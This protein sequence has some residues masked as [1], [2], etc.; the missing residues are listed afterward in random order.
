MF[1]SRRDNSTLILLD[2]LRKLLATKPPVR[3]MGDLFDY[4]FS[5][6]SKFQWIAPSTVDLTKNNSA[7]HS[8]HRGSGG[9]LTTRDSHPAT[10]LQSIHATLSSMTL[11]GSSSSLSSTSSMPLLDVIPK[12]EELKW[13]MPTQDEIC[14]FVFYELLEDATDG[15]RYHFKCFSIFSDNLCVGER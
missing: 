13:A 5:F 8:G 10:T 12:Q 6:P 15:V 9:Q 7:Q 4:F 1:V 11:G 2:L 3:K 14:T